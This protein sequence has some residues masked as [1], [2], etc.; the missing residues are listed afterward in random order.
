MDRAEA[1]RA[2]VSGW[3][4]WE[5]EPSEFAWDYTDEEH[6]Y[7]IEGS[8]EIHTDEGTVRIGKGDYV[9]FPRGLKCT[10]VVKESLTKHYCFR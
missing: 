4:T 7:V 6:C 8:A 10:W 5:K 2:G 1:E 9:V 3:G